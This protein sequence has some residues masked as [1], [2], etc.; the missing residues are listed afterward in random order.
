[1]SE[2]APGA[3]ADD[4]FL[5]IHAAAQLGIGLVR[6][7]PGRNICRMPIDDRHL[8]PNGVAFGGALFTLADLSLGLACTTACGPGQTCASVDAQ[9]AF[10]D[11]VERGATILCESTVLK[12]GG[13]LAFLESVLRTAEGRIVGRVMSTF[14]LSQRG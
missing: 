2:P 6:A 10:Y 4:P 3:R 12:K 11:P 14:S 8:N 5:G 9:M 7:E 13:R 1:M